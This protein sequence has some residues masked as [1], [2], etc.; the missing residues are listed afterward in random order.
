MLFR[1][2]SN[3]SKAC[4]R[5]YYGRMHASTYLFRSQK[6]REN[7]KLWENFKLISDT[8]RTLLSYK[9]NIDVLTRELEETNKKVMQYQIALDDQVTKTAFTY[10]SLENPQIRPE[11]ILAGSEHFTADMR[12]TLN[13]NIRL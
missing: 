4:S 3:H 8:Y 9:I 5:I 2:L 13:N 12:E 11:S 10:T 6:V 1:S 7:K